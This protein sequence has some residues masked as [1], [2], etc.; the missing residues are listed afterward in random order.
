MR[1]GP[2]ERVTRAVA[3][4]RALVTGLVNIAIERRP[5]VLRA[6]ARAR[7]RILSVSLIGALSACAS[8]EQ[9][10]ASHWLE[11]EIVDWKGRP[12]P[13][14]ELTI[15]QDDGAQ[16]IVLDERGRWNSHD[17]ATP[18]AA[19]VV[20]PNLRAHREK[21]PSPVPDEFEPSPN[22]IS[23]SWDG[24]YVRLDP[25]DRHYRLVAKAVRPGFSL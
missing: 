9:T 23:I 20:L 12:F 1:P 18:G 7:R 13:E 6:R 4:V 19:M 10:P 24:E 2:I 15:V 16:N 21:R 8:S 22:D 17:L 25:L 3:R 11:L 14:L 5:S